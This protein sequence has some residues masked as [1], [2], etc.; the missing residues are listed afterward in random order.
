MT[1]LFDKAQSI[2]RD[3]R[4][5][6]EGEIK[7]PDHLRIIG[8]LYLYSIIDG[9]QEDVEETGHEIVDNWTRKKLGIVYEGD[10][11]AYRNID[12][13]EIFNIGLS[14]IRQI[15]EFPTIVE[16][17]KLDCL[18]WLLTDGHH[19]D[20]ESREKCSKYYWKRIADYLS[21]IYDRFKAG[22]KKRWNLQGK[23]VDKE[24]SSNV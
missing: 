4:R 3:L 1:S 2:L 12:Q 24:N 6:Y 17:E 18:Y 21:R 8:G 9:L 10:E 11:E 5:A 22:W 16:E 20:H 23:N 15:I 13:Y 7:L 19:H 14:I